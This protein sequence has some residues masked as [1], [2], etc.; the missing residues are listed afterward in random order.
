MEINNDNTPVSWAI[1]PTF[2]GSRYNSG[3]G[4]NKN[5]KNT[6]KLEKLRKSNI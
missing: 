4:V 5:I 1:I 2:G 6:I 3:L